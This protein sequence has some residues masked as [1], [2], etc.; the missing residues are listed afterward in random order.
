MSRPPRLCH[1]HLLILTYQLSHLQYQ[2]GHHH[3]AAIQF[4]SI[5]KF[6]LPLNP[7]RKRHYHLRRPARL[8]HQH[9]LILRDQCN[10]LQYHRRH[11]HVAAI[12]F[13]SIHK[14][15]L[16]LNSHRYRHFQMRRPPRL[17]HHH[18]LILSDQRYHLY[19]QGGHHHVAAIQ[20]HS[21]HKFSLPLNFDRERHY[22]IRRPPRL[23]YQHSLILRHQR[24]HQ[25]HQG[26]YHHVAAIQFHSIHK[27]SLPLQTHR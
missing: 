4:H 3:V 22:Y 6:S 9:L 10:H 18:L 7:S 15:S 25:Q 26:G 12:Q 16:P 14:F 27:F 24:Y 1:H 19:Y 8:C 20:F 23:C 21:I 11:H 13:H 17:C 2:G 5:H